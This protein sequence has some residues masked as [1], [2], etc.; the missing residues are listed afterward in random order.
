MD[1]VYEAKRLIDVARAVRLSKRL[2]AGE[3]RPRAEI[4]RRQRG[5]MQALE[6]HAA[7]RSAYYREVLGGGAAPVLTKATLMERFDDIVCD[8]SLRRD[9]LVAHLDGLDHDALYRGRYRVMTTSGSSGSKALFVYDR[10]GWAAILA[11]YLRFTEIASARPRIP[12]ARLAGVS[13]GLPTH[14]T[15]R[16]AA[17]LDVGLHK[18]LALPVTTPL[19]RIV[20][21]L[22]AF[23]PRFLQ[24]F[25]SRGIRCP[26]ASG[27][28]S[29]S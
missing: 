10:D 4:E 18:L 26:T 20:T 6:R 27:A 19:D 16:I 15:R 7:A 11:Q 17:T 2:A 3:R 22:N 8:P 21:E 24:V 12:R 5:S 23:G 9:D 13:G 25:P 14:M 28:R 29:C 1:P